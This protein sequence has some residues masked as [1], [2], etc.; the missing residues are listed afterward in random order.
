VSE[1]PPFSQGFTRAADN[2]WA[3]RRPYWETVQR[4]LNS[5]QLENMTDGGF[6]S[7]SDTTWQFL[8]G[9]IILRNGYGFA[10]P[11]FMTVRGIRALHALVD[12]IGVKHPR[13]LPEDEREG[14]SA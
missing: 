3:I 6:M 11:S 1:L 12:M 8:D 14:P 4:G 5:L 13:R 7:S 2:L 10:N 9:E